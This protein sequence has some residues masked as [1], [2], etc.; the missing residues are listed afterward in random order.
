MPNRSQEVDRFMSG[1]DHPLKEGVEQLRTAILD[2]NDQIMEHIKWNAPSFRYAGEDRVTFRLYPEDRAQLVFHRGSKVKIDAED[3]A[4]EDDTGLLRWVADDR[5][6][7][8][9]QDVKDTEAKQRALV[10][11]VNRWVET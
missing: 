6:V 10:D 5:A 7:V 4:F 1:L 3:F 2:S 11:I 8:A 9:L